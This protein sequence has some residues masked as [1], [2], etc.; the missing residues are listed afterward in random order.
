MLPNEPLPTIPRHDDELDYQ[1]L[2]EMG[3][4]WSWVIWF[5]VIVLAFLAWFCYWAW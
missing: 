4:A 3:K 1:R 5:V 2:D